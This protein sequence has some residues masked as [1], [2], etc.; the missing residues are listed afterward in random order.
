MKK[1]Q[2]G[3]GLLCKNIPPSKDLGLSELIATKLAVD[4][5][6][7]YKSKPL[8]VPG[9]QKHE[10]DLK[11]WP[12]S[13]FDILD[14]SLFRGVLKGEVYMMWDALPAHI[15][16]ITSKPGVR[17]TRITIQ[18]NNRLVWTYPGIALAAV[19]HHMAHAY[20]LVCCG[21]PERPTDNDKRTLGHGLGYSTLIC[22]IM[23]VFQKTEGRK[24]MDLSKASPTGPPQPN[25]QVANLRGPQKA[26]PGETA[27][28]L[29]DRE[30][31][32]EDTCRDHLLTLSKMKVSELMGNKKI[33][34]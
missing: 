31:L 30:Q 3:K 21:F 4:A 7:D 1:Q 23:E 2:S 5:L 20:F 8:P 18:L 9:C 16:G 33:N 10:G 32:P 24:M 17:D 11:F 14:A 6:N 15:H 22:K 19:I 13:I 27:C 28:S 26:T 34:P 29:R 12:F 25:N